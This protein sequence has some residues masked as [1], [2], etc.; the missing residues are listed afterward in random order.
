MAPAVGSPTRVA[1]SSQ[2]MESSSFSPQRSQSEAG[3][4]SS[5]SDQQPDRIARSLSLSRNGDLQNSASRSEEYRQLF[6]LP[7]EEGHMYLFDHYICFYSNIFGYETK[8]II[9]FL[10]VTSVRRAKTAGIFPNAIEI[11]AAGR[12]HFFA[13]FLSRDEAFKLIYDGW[14]QHG[15]GLKGLLDHQDSKSETSSQSNGVISVEKLNGVDTPVSELNSDERNLELARSRDTYLPSNQENHIAGVTASKGP[16]MVEEKQD[17]LLDTGPSTSSVSV[18]WNQETQDAPEIPKCYTKV[19]QAK[20]PINVE[21]FFNL[22]FSDD[23]FVEA[24][25]KKCGDRDLRCTSWSLHDKSRYTRE[26]TFQHPIRM[27]LGAKCG[28]C[29]E[30]QK[31]QVYKNSHLVIETSQEVSDVPYADYFQVEGLWDVQKDG[32]QSGEGCVLQVY[33]NVA[34]SKKTIWKGKIEQ[35][36]MEECRE[37]YATWIQLAHELLK[38]KNIEKREGESVEADTLGQEIAGQHEEHSDWLHGN[39]EPRTVDTITNLEAT[40]E[41]NGIR[42]RANLVDAS[43]FRAAAMKFGSF[44]KRQGNLQLSLV[45]AFSVILLLMQFSIVVLLSKPQVHIIP[46]ADHM[47]SQSVGGDQRVDEAMHWV[48]KRMHL[49]KDEM[50]VVEAQLERMRNEHNLLKAQLND[51]ERLNR[52]LS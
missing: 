3:S 7:A 12:K 10:D 36:T 45:I 15:N 1:P 19:A 34:F 33:V 30:T 24:F 51:L 42:L 37:A 29:K 44:L 18:K 31:F 40:H 2:T 6:H 28:S 46:Q 14:S 43:I 26:I 32:E 48:E 23:A 39:A 38:Q 47:S 11:V 20:F 13:S 22:F 8:K 16:E 25:H 41:Q 4:E 49:L 17:T 52:Q 21:R 27:Y 9:P 50:L 35:A 5:S